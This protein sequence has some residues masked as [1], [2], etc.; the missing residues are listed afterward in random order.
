MME[1]EMV[2][3]HYRLNGYEFGQTLGDGEGQE[4]LMWYSPWS[5]KESDMAETEQQYG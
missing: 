2:C 3:C 4:S 5:R 1:D